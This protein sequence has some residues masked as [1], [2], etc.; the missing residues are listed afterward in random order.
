M[1][2]SHGTKDFRNCIVQN[3]PI[4]LPSNAIKG[5]RRYKFYLTFVPPTRRFNKFAAIL[6]T[7]NHAHICP[8]FPL[9]SRGRS[10]SAPPPKGVSMYIGRN[11]YSKLRLYAVGACCQNNTPYPCGLGGVV[12]VCLFMSVITWFFHNGNK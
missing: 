12:S 2:S 8:R 5:L 7:K 4:L 10:P 3:T 1:D 6:A 9:Y 11:F